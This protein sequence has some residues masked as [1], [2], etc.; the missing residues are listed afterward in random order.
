M[1]MAQK[2]L[3]QRITVKFNLRIFLAIALISG[4]ALNLLLAVL[5]V[6][7]K[8]T[9]R[10]YWS[11]FPELKKT[12]NSSIYVDKKGD[13]IDDEIIYSY[14]GG[15]FIN[16][17]SP[18]LINPETPPLGKY[19]IG[20]SIL[21][22]K[23]ENI[24]ILFSGI[25]SL[26]LLFLIGKQLFSSNITALIPPLILSFEPLFK[27]QFVRAP[28]LD[29]MHLAFMLFAF[30]FF[31]KAINTRKN[32]LLYFLAACLFLGGFISTKFFGVGI[33]L[34][35][36]WYLSI[37]IYKNK[38]HLFYLSLAMPLS[39]IV[40]LFTYVRVLFTD[41][42][43]NQF[44]GIQKWIFLYNKGHIQNA[45][46]VWPLL[47]FNQWHTWWGTR[48]ILSDAQ[49]SILWP[50]SVLITLL[51]IIFYILGKLPK[52]RGIEMIMA[53]IIFYLALL[54][55]SDATVRY[56]VILLPM[57]YLVSVFGLESLILYFL[58]KSRRVKK[59]NNS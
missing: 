33:S 6:K 2:K 29:I 32:V 48:A 4:I 14:A 47:L 42:P 56:F 19:L 44:L 53:W 26:F 49:W 54:S 52:K 3:K 25:T 27:N 15:A 55:L 58:G 7:E 28:L 43:L 10:D 16:G 24:I 34:I 5:P 45:F 38:N 41:Y 46:T 20:L 17:V 39:I 31:I 1:G 12:F 9:S 22:F 8:Y 57:L 40:L 18:I 37:I 59:A 23:N 21:F 13:F 11:R 51:T 30:Y 35:A 50:I 36:A